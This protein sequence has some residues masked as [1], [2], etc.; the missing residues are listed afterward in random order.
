MNT[1]SVGLSIAVHPRYLAAS[2]P[3]PIRWLSTP[4]V[5][6]IALATA[7]GTAALWSVVFIVVVAMIGGVSPT[8]IMVAFLTDPPSSLGGSLGLTP[9]F[10][11]L[12]APTMLIWAIGAIGTRRAIERLRLEAPVM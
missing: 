1:T 8:A 9:V 12:T 7:I 4:R 6:A 3:V 11:G 5:V 10:L 2:P